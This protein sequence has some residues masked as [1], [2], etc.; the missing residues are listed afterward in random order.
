MRKKS[1]RERLRLAGITQGEVAEALNLSR[2]TVSR[3]LLGRA[4]GWQPGELLIIR[5]MLEK[6]EGKN[7]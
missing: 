7:G 3:R 1:L 6:K 5:E 2:M 4:R